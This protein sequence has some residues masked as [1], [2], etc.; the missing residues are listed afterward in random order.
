MALNEY[1]WEQKAHPKTQTAADAQEAARKGNAKALNKAAA[2][3]RAS[4]K[5]S[6]AAQKEKEY[7]N[8]VAG[9]N[10]PS[11]EA[12][13]KKPAAP[14]PVNPK[15]QTAK[16]SAQAATKKA[17]DTNTPPAQGGTNTIPNT[18]RAVAN[19]KP[20]DIII[21]SSGDPYILKAVD[22]AWARKKLGL[23]TPVP[24][25]QPVTPPAPAPV[26]SPAPAPKRKTNTA[27]EY[28]IEQAKKQ[29]PYSQMTT[30][31]F[32]KAVQSGAIKVPRN[33]IAIVNQG[34]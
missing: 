21:L 9:L 28:E 8:S 2:D 20:G 22:V 6:W 25:D 3:E 29:T 27:I 16:T 32:K 11:P 31:D 12:E 17:L 26:A 14:A 30:R 33:I 4:Q 23:D 19:A 24:Q 10:P 34:V 7:S 18:N 1:Q 13:P 15:E 5:P